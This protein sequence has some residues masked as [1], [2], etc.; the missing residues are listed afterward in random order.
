MKAL[1]FNSGLGSR[2]GELTAN[3]P[4]SMVELGSGETIFHRQLRVLQACGLREFVVTT[5]PYPEQ[6]EAVAREFEDMGCTFHFVNNPIYDQTNYIHSMWLARD[7][8]RG[9]EVLLMH[10]DLVFDA[11]YVTGMLG[12]PSGSYGSVDATLPLPE[13]DFKARV[14]GGE[15]REV[16]VN[17]W[18]EDCLAFQAMYRLAPKAVDIWLD[19]ID[20][21]EARG[22][23]GV[24]AENAANEVFADMHIAAHS[25][26]G[27]VLEE[28]DTPED[29]A[30]VS[31]MIRTKDF[32]DQPTFVLEDGTSELVGGSPAGRVLRDP[33][34]GS[35]I[36][37]CGLRRPL[38]VADGFL[39][40]EALEGVLGAGDWPVFSGYKPNPT[41]EQVLEAVRVFR[42][43]GCDSV[44]SV[45][46]GSAIDVA[47]C[48]KLWAGLSG[49]RS[50]CDGE[51]PRYCDLPIRFS[52]E[53]HVAVPTTAGTGSESTHFAVVYVDGE[54]RSVAADC[55]QPDVAVLAPELLA[56]LPSGQRRATM[57]DAL[58]QA[59]ESHWSVASSAE[60]R[61]YSSRAIPMVMGYW[62]AYLEGDT[63]AARTM[64]E[65]A[66]LAGRAI[67]LTTTT[68]AHA[69]SYKLTSL[70]GI[71]HGHA[72]AL[73]MPFA[74]RTLL[75][76]GDEVTQKRLREI[77]ALMAGRE[78]APFG[79]GLKVLE[80]ILREAGYSGEIHA[81]EESLDV[82]AASVNPQRMGNYPV[83][84]TTDE[85][86]DAYKVIL[87]V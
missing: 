5:G 28:I 33:R 42:D 83:R 69:M 3:R 13:K 11:A 21:F 17:T 87:G 30:R 12:F 8:L 85:L 35:V 32:A 74:W 70:Y 39:T 76:R 77:D 57:L 65:A 7:L 48:V 71:P 59:V 84:L 79:S 36:A 50:G 52:G 2:L 43:G 49:D 82:L 67:N 63:N 56:G 9:E 26:S 66:N 31:A 72:V 62:R 10:G 73:C 68:L 24:Y 60:S 34:L 6:L 61:A 54:K 80:E 1:I 20:E 4:K 86:R 55:L 18:G 40:R 29:L 81:D 27:H 15:V 51:N 14:V 37:D 58:C 53:K 25:Y 64:H 45:G 16:G 46:G 23:T 22:E 41:Y 78:D 19:R 75:E 44:V 47:K 38:V